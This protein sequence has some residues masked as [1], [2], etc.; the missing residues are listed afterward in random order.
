[1][2]ALRVECKN[3]Q[4]IDHRQQQRRRP[5]AAEAGEQGNKARRQLK[6]RSFVTFGADGGEE[7]ADGGRVEEFLVTG[8]E[9][10]LVGLGV[11]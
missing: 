4:E 1:M 8:G 5:A 2:A 9:D 3:A 11:R 7:R 10:A 6:M